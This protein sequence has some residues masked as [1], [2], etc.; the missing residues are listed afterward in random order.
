MRRS[1]FHAVVLATIVFAPACWDAPSIPHAV[2]SRD[3]ESCLSC[4]REGSNGAPRT[5]HP[6]KNGCVTCHEVVDFRTPADAGAE[7]DAP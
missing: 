7:V 5:P 3:D 1:P 6:N 2:S 4:H